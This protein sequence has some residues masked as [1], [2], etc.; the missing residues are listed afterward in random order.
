MAL[1]KLSISR[2]RS[3]IYHLTFLI[4]HFLL[5]ICLPACTRPDDTWDRMRETGV[6]RVGMDASFPPFE[7]IA[8][9]GTLVGFDVDLARELARRLGPALPAPSVAEG[10]EA[11]GIEV[12]F[13]ANLPYDGL[14]DA[15]AVDRVDVVI[16]ALVVNPARMADFAYSTPYFDAGQVLV[17][18]AVGTGIEKQGPEPV[19]GMSDL[20]GRTLAVEFGTQG[21][22]EARKWARRLSGLTIMPYQTAAEALAAVAAGEADAA[23]VDHV[24][25]LAA[26]A[27]TLGVSENPKGLELVIVGDPVIEEPYAVAVHRGSQHLLRAI[28]RA[29][30]EMQADG[31]LEALAARWLEEGQ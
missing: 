14:Y 8:P 12:Q 20:A 19:E 26:T 4:C 22:L 5:V 28:N 23:L 9:D 11:E 21:D 29:L 18:R 13:V 17:V 6:L 2:L 3:P 31:A 7:T 15:L 16:S 25:A 10:S 1:S 30:A 24:S 27:E